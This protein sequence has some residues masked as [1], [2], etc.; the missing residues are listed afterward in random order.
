VRTPQPCQKLPFSRII[1]ATALIRVRAAHAFASPGVTT[2]APAN[3]LL[4]PLSKAH[5][6]SNM[7][8]LFLIKLEPI[9]TRSS[10]FSNEIQGHNERINHGRGGIRELIF[11][12]HFWFEALGGNDR[13]CQLYCSTKG[14]VFFVAFDRNGSFMRESSV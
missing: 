13:K 4:N 3:N 10:N 7:P 6:S 5:G 8:A 11:I 2:G 12:L 9:N 14:T 1:S